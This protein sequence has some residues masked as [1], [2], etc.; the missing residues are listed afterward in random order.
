MRNL[1]INFKDNLAK[2]SEDLG[3]DL[4]KFTGD[5]WILFFDSNFSVAKILSFL[6]TLSKKFESDFEESIYRYLE[7]PPDLIGLTFCMDSGALYYIEMLERNEWVGRA[8]NIACR[9][10]GTLEDTDILMGYSVM[11]S[12][13]LFQLT[14][15]ELDDFHPELVKRR[16][17]NIIRGG[18]F[19]CYRLSVSEIPFKIIKAT[20]YTQNNFNI[21]TKELIAQIK[22]NCIDIIVGNDILGG[23]PERGVGKRLRVEYI[24]NGEPL[25]K[26]VIEG[27]RIQLP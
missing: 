22:R 27:S 5:G 24:S 2:A 23:D 16:L 1:L 11:I 3:F 7:S 6:S 15:N 26:D 19:P 17:K 20:Y 14:K 9:L 18:E 12:N 21:V 25:S 8:I 4:Y 13:N 10:Q